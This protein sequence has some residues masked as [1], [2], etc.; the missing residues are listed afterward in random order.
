M[1][2]HVHEQQQQ[3]QQQAANARHL[4]TRITTATSTANLLLASKAIA[5]HRTTK[6]FFSVSN[7]H[8][9]ILV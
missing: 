3:Q 7:D 1:K 9:C 5:A 8:T 4:S 2:V 6:R